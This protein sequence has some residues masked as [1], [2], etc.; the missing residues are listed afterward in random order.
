[1][2]FFALTFPFYFYY[3][4]ATLAPRKFSDFDLELELRLLRLLK[5]LDYLGWDGVGRGWGWDGVGVGRGWGGMGEGW[6]NS[7]LEVV[8]GPQYIQ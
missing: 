7:G 6:V 1:M 8:G 5:Y 3:S 4:L 2:T